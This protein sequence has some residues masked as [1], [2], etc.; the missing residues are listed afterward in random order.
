MPDK[1]QRATKNKVTKGVRYPFP[2]S[3][4]SDILNVCL[5]SIVPISVIIATMS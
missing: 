4:I 1:G 3:F 5:A 2:F